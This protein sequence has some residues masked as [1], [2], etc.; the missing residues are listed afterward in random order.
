[1]ALKQELNQVGEKPLPLGVC[2]N[3]SILV[4]TRSSCREEE[5]SFLLQ[6]EPTVR[7]PEKLE[8]RWSFSLYLLLLFPFSF[9]S[10]FL[11]LISFSTEFFGPK[12]SGMSLLPYVNTPLTLFGFPSS[13]YPKLWIPVILGGDTCPT[14]A[15]LRLLFD[16]LFI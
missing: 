16:L 5:L 4:S 1:M 15:P 12:S 9:F 7:S 3:F 14:W 2:R 10:F 11:R 6:R 13:I 8:R